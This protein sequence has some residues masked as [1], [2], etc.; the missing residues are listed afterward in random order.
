MSSDD[1]VVICVTGFVTVFALLSLL[2]LLMRLLILVF[3]EK[4]R[5]E[6]D[7]AMIAAL[8]MT[9]SYLYPGSRIVRIEKQ[10]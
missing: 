1:F 9:M 7:A 3:P 4:E 10:K 8:T 6:S 2:A 5:E